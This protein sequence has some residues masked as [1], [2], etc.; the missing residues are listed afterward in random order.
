M[1]WLANLCLII[2]LSTVAWF[3]AGPAMPGQPISGM[4][5]AAGSDQLDADPYAHHGHHKPGD[6]HK[7]HSACD[8]CPVVFL[9]LPN[10]GAP[11]T[12][13]NRY[14]LVQAMRPAGV[15]NPRPALPLTEDHPTRAPPQQTSI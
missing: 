9:T 4:V 12:G 6:H 15:T 11:E 2:S 8:N 10:A 1:R 3:S 5:M 7:G 13:P 14:Q